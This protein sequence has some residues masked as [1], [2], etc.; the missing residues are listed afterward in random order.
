MNLGVYAVGTLNKLFIKGSYSEINFL[1]I[2]AVSGKLMQLVIDPFCTP[3]SISLNTRF[4]QGSFV[5]K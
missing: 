4:W 3:L 1:K 5:L 2:N